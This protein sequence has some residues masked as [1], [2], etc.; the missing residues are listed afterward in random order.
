MKSAF[1]WLCTVLLACLPLFGQTGSPPASSPTSRAAADAYTLT[2]ATLSVAVDGATGQ[3]RKLV[4]KQANRDLCRLEDARFGMIGGL[5]V[6]D[7]LS[8]KTYDDFGTPST[9]KVLEW[10]DGPGARRL[11]MDKQFEGAGFTLRL[12]FVLD[13]TCLQ[14]DVYAR[15]TAGPDRQIRLTYLLPQPYSNLWA[16]MNEPIHR[17]RWEEPFQV[18]HGLAYGRSVQQEHCTALIPM[19]TLFDRGRSLAYA[20][21][22]DVPNVCVRF[23]NSASEDSLFLLNSMNYSIDQRPHFKV[24]NDYLSLRDGKQTRFSLL[25]SPQKSPWRDALGWYSQRFSAWFRPDPRIRSHEGVYSITVPWDKNPDESLAEP[26]LAG[27]AERGVKWMELHGHFPWYGLYVHPEPQWDTS[28]GPMSYDKVRRYIDLVKKHGIAV[29]IYYNT[30]DGQIPYIDKNFPKSVARDEDGKIIRAYTDC[31]LMNADPATPFGQHCL[32]QF[33]KLLAT[34]PNIDGIFYDVYGRHYNIDFAHDD[35]LT[36]VNNKPAYCMKFAFQR[37]MDQIEPMARAKGMVFSANKP[38]ALELLRGIDYIM[39]DEGSDEDRLAAMQYYGLYKPIIIL[40]GGIVT[41]AEGDFKKCLRYGMIYN[42]L[43]PGREMK[44]KQA[45]DE[46][47]RQAREALK[48]YGPLFKLLIGKTWVLEGD[49][50]VL[51]AG[52]DG[53]IFRRPDGDYI[54]TMVSSD[55]SLFDDTPSRKDVKVTIRVP[56]ADKIAQAEVYAADWKGAKPAVIDHGGKKATATGPA[57]DKW[58]EEEAQVET[59]RDRR[60]RGESADG[61]TLV[62]TVPELKTAG[63]LVLK[64]AS[65]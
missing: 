36:M 29:H 58:K 35:G 30:I 14:W 24:V 49:P 6:K 63:V 23:M 48:A 47:R 34:Y 9:V 37:I 15:K 56:D 4:D 13:D 33:R 64:Q 65:R 55:R 5:R 40:D 61:N 1:P 17:L 59:R 16:P 18:R 19:V 46:M 60:D 57:S 7:M 32:D 45:T 52:F 50:L 38:E 53:N 31:H 2:N 43:D 51:P 39:A 3:I 62:V 22:A 8:G 12:E 21:P 20:V 27:R 26:A 54:V 11:V 28:W 42:D 41:R 10:K 25:I 44:E